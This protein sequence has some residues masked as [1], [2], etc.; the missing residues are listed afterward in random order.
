MLT[1]TQLFASFYGLV[2]G[3]AALCVVVP[4]VVAQVLG[5]RGK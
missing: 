1:E 2:V 4:W 3:L 5:R